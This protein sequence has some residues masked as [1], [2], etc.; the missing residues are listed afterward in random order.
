MT[1]R[2]VSRGAARVGPLKL[3]NDAALHGAITTLEA[4]A[5]ASKDLVRPRRTHAIQPEEFPF[6]VLVGS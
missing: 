4:G 6:V 3:G 2:P 1:P 5:R